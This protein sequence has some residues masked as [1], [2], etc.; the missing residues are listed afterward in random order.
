MRLG[1]AWRIG[2]VALALGFLT[3]FVGGGGR[4]A[5][6][7]VLKPMAE[8]LAWDRTLLGAV[9]AV[10]MGATAVTMTVVGRL[11]DRYPVG[12]ILAGGF[13]VLSLIHI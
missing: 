4:H 1:Q 2:G 3:L 10:F 13:L 6:G 8:S 7:L 5:I 11:A 12:W 9:I